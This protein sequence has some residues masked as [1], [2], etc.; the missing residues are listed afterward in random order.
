V[1]ARP[2]TPLRAAGGFTLIELLVAMAVLSI[3]IPVFAVFIST[4]YIQSS[5]TMS[6]S[7]LQTQTRAVVDT[8]VSDLRQAYYGDTTTSPI[9]SISPTAVTFYAPDRAQP[10]HL[11]EIAYQ[12]SGGKLQRAFGV[13][14]NTNGPPWTGITFGAWM[15]QLDN[16]TNTTVFTYQDAD[17]NTTTDPA[18]VKRITVQVR[19]KPNSSHAATA[20]YQ[21]SATIR[22]ER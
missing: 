19:A 14:S 12:L 21:S 2:T 9:V 10:F 5:R 18:Q 6:Q 4:T 16:V 15:T 7:A 17:G 3:A 8:L 20:S 1:S 13:S 22:A 11:R